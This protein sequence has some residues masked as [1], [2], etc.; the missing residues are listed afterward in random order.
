MFVTDKGSVIDSKESQTL[1]A[2]F[3]IFVTEEGIVIDF[4][5]LQ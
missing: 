4:K 5:E 3:P 1:K 2:S